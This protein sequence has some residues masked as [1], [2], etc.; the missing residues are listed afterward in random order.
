MQNVWLQKG[1]LR[2]LVVRRKDKKRRCGNTGARRSGEGR[3]TSRKDKLIRKKVG[4]IF[5][6]YAPQVG[7]PEGEKEAFLGI[8]NDVTTVAR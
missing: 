7:R 2:V 8:L 6:V 1:A 4:S 5:S 3:D